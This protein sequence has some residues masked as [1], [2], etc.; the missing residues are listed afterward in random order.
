MRLA[1]RLAAWVCLAACAPTEPTRSPSSTAM[2]PRSASANS[3]ETQA[4]A[5]QYRLITREPASSRVRGRPARRLPSGLKL[6]DESGKLILYSGHRLEEK[7]G[8][9]ELADSVATTEL[10]GG[11]RFPGGAGGYVF[12][13]RQGL[14][15]SRTFLGKL[16]PLS[17][18]SFTPDRVAFGP[19]FLLAASS[20]GARL[21]LDPQSGVPVAPTP[22]GLLDVASSSDGRV[23]ATLELGRAVV[24]LDRNATHREVQNELGAAV[25]GL[26][27]EP[28]GFVLEGGT[29]V[30]VSAAGQLVRSAIEQPE[31]PD[32]SRW[33]LAETPL[34]H[35]VTHGVFR[36]PGRAWVAASAALA[37]VDLQKGE[38]V[39]IGPQLLP[40]NPDC[41][42]LRLAT[43]LLMTCT[44][45]DA[46]VIVN[47]LEGERPTVE[48][49]F[50]GAPQVLPG[51]GQL[52]VTAAC[53]GPSKPFSVCVRSGGG[54]WKPLARE[55]A[56]AGGSDAGRAG[57]GGAA[58]SAKAEEP[59][60]YALKADG[61]VVAFVN[62]ARSGLVD[63]GNGDFT[64]VPKEL[65]RSIES[66]WCVVE[67]SG[68]LRCLSNQG[69]L[70]VS[71]GGTPEPRPFRYK[72]M[73]AWPPHAL[74]LDDQ[75]QLFQSDDSGRTWKQVQGPPILDRSPSSSSSCSEVGC[76]IGQWLR[77]G[78]EARPPLGTPKPEEVALP[79]PA[80]LL[81]PVLGCR[82]AS[83][84][85]VAVSPLLGVDEGPRL[86][87]FGTEAIS[88]RYFR[89]LIEASA[90]HQSSLGV[91]GLRGV[92]SGLVLQQQDGSAHVYAR[93]RPLGF[94]WIDY[95]DAKARKLTTTLD[96]NEIARVAQ[97]VGGSPPDLSFDDQTSFQVVPVLGSDPGKSAGF[98]LSH[99]NAHAWVRAGQ[100]SALPLEVADQV[101]SIVSGVA[102][103]NGRLLLL[104]DDG[105]GKSHV[106]QLTGGASS[107]IFTMPSG[108]TSTALSSTP[109]ALAV[110]SDGDV[111]VLHV[112]SGDDPPSQAYPLLAYRPGKPIEQLA[113][114]ST[115]K[116][117]SDPACADKAGYRAVVMPMQ[118]WLA[119]ARS[120]ADAE[121]DFGMI[122]AVRWSRERVCLE[123]LEI[124]D[125]PFNV[126]DEELLTRVAATFTVKPEAARLGF[127][128]G[129]ELRQPLVCELRR[130]P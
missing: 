6:L 76:R 14:Y 123:A 81:K 47:Q 35:A 64:P 92:A 101:W 82:A 105:A 79:A 24:S 67:L 103:R 48:K 66:G 23:V 11:A 84:P 2:F 18:T 25:T 75:F 104:V 91:T 26:S 127:A 43:E 39:S 50:S 94:R 32:D 77:L 5:G 19:G 45:R 56:A 31:K 70:V 61:G 95:F 73:E 120:E 78:W 98:I 111:A 49:T 86:P 93:A 74:A 40:G 65:T 116:A 106:L 36:A 128:Q 9:Y 54:V 42:L 15:R 115:L 12:W 87:A 80:H 129:M 121:Q 107:L 10:L 117:A 60:G 89:L 112:T 90:P 34:E 109:D 46:L 22:L 13:S 110:T 20:D 41:R 30:S 124:S 100:A 44:T 68:A 8:R 119:L 88:A 58:P 85:S 96:L 53:D 16:Q 99:E 62:G 69:P 71:P 126:A 130:A 37:E 21:A 125:N 7:P 4:P 1:S 33:P 55:Q 102:E 113:P 122:A 63:L 57:A 72:W 108:V 52:V 59:S 51:F 17:A 97:S 3:F 114:W 118:G 38:L 83:A 28:L 27:S 29:L